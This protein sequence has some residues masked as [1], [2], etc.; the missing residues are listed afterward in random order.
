MEGGIVTLVIYN[1][2][3]CITIRLWHTSWNQE[4]L[5]IHK[6]MLKLEDLRKAFNKMIHNLQAHG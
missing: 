6:D 1:G 5:E 2:S 3:D 4:M